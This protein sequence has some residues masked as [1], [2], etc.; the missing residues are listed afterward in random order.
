[1]DKDHVKAH[2]FRGRSQAAVEE[3]DNAVKTLTRLCEIDGN[4]DF[5]KELETVKRLKSQEVKKQQ[6]LYSKM[7]K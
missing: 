4:P 3:F 1:M 5:V 6:N 7:F 2:F